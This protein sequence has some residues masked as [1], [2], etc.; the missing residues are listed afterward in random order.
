[1][2]L[3]VALALVLG[4]AAAPGDAQAVAA[5]CGGA[6]LGLRCSDVVVPLDRS[7]AV[8][9]SI[10]L[11]VEM[12]PPKGTSRG[13]VFLV[14]G[15]PGQGSAHVFDLA[16]SNA[17]QLFRF[18]FPDYTLVAYDDRG[19][20]ASG[21]I[22][23]P[24]FQ[25]STSFNGEEL[26]AAACATSLGARAPFYGT[27]DHAADLDAVRASLG[28][29]KVTI[30]GVSYGTKLALAY[31]SA[32][33]THVAGLVLD[34]VLPPSEPD[35]FNANVARAI[36]SKLA[37]YCSGGACRAATPNFAGDV[38]AVA[39]RLQA[40]P[41]HGAV[42]Q[43]NGKLKR[44]TLDGVDLVSLVIDADLVPGL[45]PELP[46]AV[47]AARLGNTKPLL[48]LSDLDTQ[49]SHESAVDLSAGLF[50]ATTCRD[51]P[52]PWPSDSTPSERASLLSQALAA[53]PAGSFG[54]FGSWASK[55]GNAD[56]CVDWPAP[57]GDPSVGAK[58]YPN[59]PVLVVSGGFDMRTPTDGAQS[60]VAQFPQGHLLVV[61]G[62]GHS[63]VLADLSGC[64][65][66]AVRDWI[67]SGTI[68]AATCARPKFQLTPLAAYPSSTTPRHLGTAAT[69][70]LAVKTVREA[71]AAWLMVDEAPPFPVVAGL[72][73]GKLVP[74]GATGFKLVSYSIAPGVALSGPVKLSKNTDLP[75]QFDGRLMVGGRSA[76]RGLGVL[77]L[78]R[79]KLQGAPGGKGTAL[80]SP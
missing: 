49:A 38:I 39:N 51:G 47:H 34:S 62:V 77:R 36:P 54:P 66:F 25:N 60:V 55:L 45:A 3:A 27:A 46:A 2:V 40:K 24:A 64:A 76:A 50:A 15:G 12:L 69:V 52:F 20:G 7:G 41:A 57:S 70:A 73:G 68:P 18:L 42:L 23:C 80:P 14:A 8:P 21:L 37:G 53:L 32:F 6:S 65:A 29:D 67:A 44:E 1:M 58:P 63:A 26:L 17:A 5:A 78:V 30:Y 4:V 71:E 13:V 59:V 22:D 16:S 33:P 72:Y 19:T 28:F 56:L 74:A 11:H 48:R 79:S 75:Y 31:A 9:G 10:D 43:P 35:P 61:P